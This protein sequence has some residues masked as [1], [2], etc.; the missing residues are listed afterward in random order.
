VAVNITIDLAVPL[1][2]PCP[3]RRLAVEVNAWV[4]EYCP[5]GCDGEQ[6]LDVTTRCVDCGKIITEI[7]QGHEGCK[8]GR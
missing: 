8:Y 4:L 6:M 1:C 2:D 5:K 7:H 3:H